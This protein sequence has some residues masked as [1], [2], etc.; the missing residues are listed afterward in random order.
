[1]Q[2]EIS[3]IPIYICDTKLELDL[4]KEPIIKKII[5]S[6]INEI[7]FYFLVLFKTLYSSNVID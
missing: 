1:M 2:K 5:I 3:K 7:L 6:A 4:I